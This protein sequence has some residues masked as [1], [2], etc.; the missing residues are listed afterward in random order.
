[1]SEEK[2]SLKNDLTWFKQAV[3]VGLDAVLDAVT[4]AKTDLQLSVESNLTFFQLALSIMPRYEAFV[5]TGMDKEKAFLLAAEE[6]L[7][8]PRLRSTTNKKAPKTHEDAAL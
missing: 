7:K 4:Q 5:G 8:K 3:E 1:M 2:R 6:T